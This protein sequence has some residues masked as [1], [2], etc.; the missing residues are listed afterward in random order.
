MEAIYDKLHPH[1]PFFAWLAIAAIVGRFMSREVFTKERALYRWPQAFWT[2]G[3]RTLPLHPMVAGVVVGLFYR[4]PPAL[5]TSRFPAWL[6]FGAAGALAP[7][8]YDVVRCWARKRGFEFTELD[9][10]ST[11]APPPV[12]PLQ[13]LHGDHSG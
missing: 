4:E 13:E 2:W 6:Y 12:A 1:W 3:R 7:Y 9:T 11:T 5:Q 8:L 10:S